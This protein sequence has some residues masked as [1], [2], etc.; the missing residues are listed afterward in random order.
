MNKLQRYIVKKYINSY[1]GIIALKKY[2]CDYVIDWD[3]VHK[4]FFS[5][6]K[7]RNLLDI[8]LLA[9]DSYV[10]YFNDITKNY[11]GY[12][13]YF[14]HFF[15]KCTF[16]P[17]EYINAIMP[18]DDDEKFWKDLELEWQLILIKNLPKYLLVPY[19]KFYKKK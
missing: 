15:D 3:K 8:F 4:D 11:Y 13:Y 10:K 5:F 1:D 16:R 19:K 17:S 12:Q 18:D 9:L 6:L 2:E 7:R 14:K